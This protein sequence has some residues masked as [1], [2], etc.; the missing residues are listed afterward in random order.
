MTSHLYNNTTTDSKP[1]MLSSVLTGNKI[2]HEEY[3]ICGIV[4]AHTYIFMQGQLV[5]RF[6]CIREWG[7]GTKSPEVQPFNDLYIAEVHTA[8]DI[9]RFAVFF[10]IFV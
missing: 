3:H 8:V 7:Q 2:P 6:P 5:P 9:F 1:E 10:L 4:Q